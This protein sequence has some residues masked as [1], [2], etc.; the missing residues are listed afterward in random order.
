VDSTFFEDFDGTLARRDLPPLRE[1]VWHPIAAQWGRWP[2]D[3]F[4]VTEITPAQAR[5]IAGPGAELYV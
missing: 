4:T 2:I 5:A 1:W 3:P